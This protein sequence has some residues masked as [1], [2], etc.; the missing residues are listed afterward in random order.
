MYDL[1][2]ATGGVSEPV[3]GR[4]NA[5]RFYQNLTI[6]FLVEKRD[7][8]S[9]DRAQISK[10]NYNGVPVHSYPDRFPLLRVAIKDIRGSP[11]MYS[12]Q[13]VLENRLVQL[14]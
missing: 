9:I 12:G 5:K 3:Y 4:N 14:S 11:F 13:A 2:Y 10:Y 1:G 7:R 8:V 6:E